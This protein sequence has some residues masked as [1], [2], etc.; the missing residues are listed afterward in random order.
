[1]VQTKTE[2]TRNI[3]K[4]KIGDMNPC[5][6]MRKTCILRKSVV[7]S[8]RTYDTY[9]FCDNL[10][11]YVIYQEC[12]E[13]FGIERIFGSYRPFSVEEFSSLLDQDNKVWEFRA[14]L[15]IHVKNLLLLGEIDSFYKKLLR[16]KMLGNIKERN[17]FKKMCVSLD[18]YPH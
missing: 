6:L 11:N 13:F 17:Y 16:S 8:F 18:G 5:D 14:I 15:N 7:D 9:D 12:S 4:Y 1:M 2:M 10:Y 3:K